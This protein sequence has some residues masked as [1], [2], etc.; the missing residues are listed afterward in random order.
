M[1]K[2]IKPK[3]YNVTVTQTI[4]I[5]KNLQHGKTRASITNGKRRLL[6]YATNESKTYYFTYA[7]DSRGR[8]GVNFK[9]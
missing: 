8:G 4:T 3:R 5:Q 2:V 7:Y 6:G 1:A 9:Y